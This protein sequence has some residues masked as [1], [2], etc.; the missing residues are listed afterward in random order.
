MGFSLRFKIIL[1]TVVVLVF[2]V[3]TTALASS[4]IF[5]QQYTEVLQSR[6]L[7]IGQ[8]IKSQLDKLLEL[9]I[10]LE[11]LSGFEKQ[12][13]VI[14]NTYDDITYVMVVNLDGKILFHNDPT[15]H[16]HILTDTATLEAIKNDNEIIELY[17]DQTGQFYDVFIPIFDR[18]G[19]HVGAIRLGF[20]VELI[21]QQIRRLALFSGVVALI[22]LIVAVIL[23]VFILSFWVTKPLT[24]LLVAIQHITSSKTNLTER[25][26][27]DSRD[28]LGEIGSAF[29]TMASQLHHLIGTLEKQVLDRTRRLEIA[30]N[31]TEHLNAIL[32]RQELL[33][34]AV[35]Q[36]KANFNYYH[37]HIYLLDD[38]REKLVVAAGTGEAGVA[39]QAK[40]HSILL[41]APTSIVARAARTGE[42]IRVDNVRVVD[43]WLSNPLLPDTASEMAVPIL[44]EGQV[45]GILDV[46]EDKVAGLDENDA[47][48]LRSLA[49]QVA[50]ALQNARNFAQVKTALVEA[51]AIQERYLDQAWQKTKFSS[52]L[53]PYL[54]TQAGVSPL[55]E[56]KRQLLYETQQQTL[57]Q[58]SPAIISGQDNEFNQ[59]ALIAPINLRGKTIGALQLRAGGEVSPWGE[60]DLAM[61]ET[62]I[63][64]V[65]QTA[66]SLRLF[67]ETR[68]RA[69][70]EQ[71]I[72]EI[73]DKLRI[74]PNLDKLL[75]TATR[76]LGQHLGAEHTVL[77][78][79]L[80]R[81]V[82]GPQEV[83]NGS[84]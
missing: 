16:N 64:Q 37:V 65:A 14:V 47:N 10:L 32:D 57:A 31:L 33:V 67:D 76:E 44:W 46:Q 24:K 41:N 2:A 62:I 83:Q 72:R 3:G 40:G 27:I 26:E 18:S 15:Q 56:T 22:S 66:E 53:E 30:A 19:A 80:E 49:N 77:R 21:N 59:H 23:L 42:V 50:T 68:E 4:Y 82:A 55:N 20:P 7:I 43:D 6:T 29:N 36:I 81:R 9:G 39:M 25:V 48:L 28:E 35:N 84:S 70:R 8:S 11:D 74:A 12:L 69:G 58:E 51:Q 1:I 13:Q 38:Q 61:I 75:E 63:D 52:R 45:V 54:Y 73:T 71:T 17:S 34:E 5:S 60:E 78:L 79:G